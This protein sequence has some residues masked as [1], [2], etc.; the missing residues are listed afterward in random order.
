MILLQAEAMTLV[1]GYPDY[2]KDEEKLNEKYKK[3]GS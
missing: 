2:I 1:V 3:V